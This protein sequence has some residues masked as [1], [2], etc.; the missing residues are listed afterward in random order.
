MNDQILVS[1]RLA[2][3]LLSVSLR[4]IDNLIAAKRL[5]SRKIGRRTLIPRS[6]V[7]QLARRDVPSPAHEAAQVAATCVNATRTTGSRRPES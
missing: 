2:A 3:A 5:T 6:A 4:T 7:E 1:K